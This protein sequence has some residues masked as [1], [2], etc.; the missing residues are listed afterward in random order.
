MRAMVFT[1]PGV[2]EMLDVPEPAP[3]SDEVLVEVR[4]AGICGSELH[5]IAN[6]G[7]RQ[8]PLVMGHEFA[9]TTRDGRR[10]TVNPIGHCRRCDLCTGG[11]ENL[12]RERSIVGIHFAGA[13]AERVAVPAYLVHELPDD[14][15]FEAAAMVEPLA[16]AVHACNLAA[17]GAG[18]RVAVLGAGTI[19][20]VTLLAALEQGAAYVDVSDLSPDRQEAAARLG[21]R[22]TGSSLEGEYDVVFDAVGAPATHTASVEL[23]RPG[24]TAIW[25]GLLSPVSAFDAQVLV[26]QEKAVRGSFA[27]TDAEFV[28]ALTMSRRCDL[29]WCQSFPL[30]Q[31]AGIFTEL[32]NGRSDVIKAVLRPAGDA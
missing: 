23:L 7:F 30:E 20:L 22:D 12:C 11:S 2:V 27:Y 18:V 5:G 21:A 28:H 24:G 3:A 15:S 13:F 1:R 29:S 16:N 32:M 4:A 10:V 6:P 26:R 31:G 8:P 19:G 9:G 25:I 14:V 17:V